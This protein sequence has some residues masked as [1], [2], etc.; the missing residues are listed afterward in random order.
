MNVFP[1]VTF[2]SR[3]LLILIC[4]NA[5]ESNTRP[6]DQNWL[7]RGINPVHFMNSLKMN[8]QKHLPPIAFRFR[9]SLYEI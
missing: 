1:T 3:S 4:S 6:T 9:N 8:K 7:K 2:C 5:G